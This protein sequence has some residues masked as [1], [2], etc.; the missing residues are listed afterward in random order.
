MLSE[1]LPGH[2]EVEILSQINVE[3]KQALR[4]LD[5]N[6]LQV[7]TVKIEETKQW[8][9]K[10]WEEVKCWGETSIITARGTT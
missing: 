8:V 10:H 7:S 6:K 4:V 2:M 9:Q 5:P 1:T 3:P